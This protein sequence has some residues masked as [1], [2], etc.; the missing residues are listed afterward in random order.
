MPQTPKNQPVGLK[1]AHISGAA[2]TVVKASPG[3]LSRIV[4]NSAAI[5]AT[6]TVFDNTAGS[7][8]AVVVVPALAAAVGTPVSAE[9]DLR[10]TTGITVVTTGTIDLTV[11][12]N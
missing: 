11:V 8:S 3:L 5:G 2:T 9:Y 4:V 10:T 6:I 1:F 12:F 7:G